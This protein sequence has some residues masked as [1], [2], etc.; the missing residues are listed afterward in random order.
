[1]ISDSDKDVN[2]CCD[3]ALFANKSIKAKNNES[4]HF[5]NDNIRLSILNENQI[6]SEMEEALKKDQFKMY[7]QAKV[8]FNTNKFVGSEALVRWIHPTKGLIPPDHFIPLFEKNGF[9]ENIDL[10]VFE[11]AC[12]TIL[13]WIERGLEPIP[14]SVNLS[15]A[16]IFKNNLPQ[17]LAGIAKK[18]NVPTKYLE[19]ELTESVV[20][21]NT[22]ILLNSLM[23]LK[24]CGFLISMDDF[25]TGYSSFHMLKD[26]P[27]DVIKLDKIFIDDITDRKRCQSI[28][29]GITTIAREININVIAEG[30]ET[31]EQV[32]FLHEAG[33]DLGQ[34]Y[35]FSRPIV[36]E[37]FE[38]LVFDI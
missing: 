1:M 23:Q 28:I 13:S 18:Y 17:V 14:I 10:Y 22:E 2:I 33:C 25:G 8:S 30:V 16:H 3:K 7:L 11:Q 12:K 20:F 6:E 9:I 21:E 5:Y 26:I 34:G 24:S 37:E 32:D 31:K 35:L 29:K 4:I 38:K 36:V 15:R 19:L 27:V